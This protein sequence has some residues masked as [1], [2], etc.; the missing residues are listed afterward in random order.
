MR[1]TEQRPSLDCPFCRIIAGEAPATVV[2]DWSDALAIEPI[3]PVTPGHVLV[4]PKAHV[5]DFTEDPSVTAI[6]M[7]R[8]AELAGELGLDATNLITSRGA[9]ATQTVYH[10]HTH[11]VPRRRGDRLALPWHNGN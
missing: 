9:E 4:I 11:L 2:A 6:T 3:G 1:T 5:A 8:A 7:R 10:L